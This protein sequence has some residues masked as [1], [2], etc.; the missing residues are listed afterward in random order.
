[1]HI[2]EL[3]FKKSLI[4]SEL[5]IINIATRRRDQ[6]LLFQKRA[7]NPAYVRSLRYRLAGAWNTLNVEQRAIK[8]IAEFSAWNKGHNFD[9]IKNYV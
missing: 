1:M 8:H 6:R 2:L 5:D 3:A 4:D 7:K 9:L